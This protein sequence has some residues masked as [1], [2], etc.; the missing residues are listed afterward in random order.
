M[1]APN[2][3]RTLGWSQRCARRFAQWIL[4]WLA[5]LG[6]LTASGCSWFRRTTPIPPPP[7]VFE[8]PPTLDQLLT[9]VNA[10][11]DRVLDVQTD[12]GRLTAE[13][14]PGLRANLRL[15]RPKHLRLQASFMTNQVLDMGS[16]AE[17]FWLW[18][19]GDPV[20]FAR[21]DQFASTAA[22]QLLPVEPTWLVD[23]LGLIHFEPTGGHR[24]PFQRSDG[25]I[26]VHTPIA[27]AAGPRVRVVAIHPQ[28]GYITE[29]QMRD[30]AGGLLAIA[31]ADRHRYDEATQVTLPHRVRLEL[32]TSQLP[33]RAFTFETDAYVINQLQSPDANPNL[34]VMPPG[35]AHDLAH[36]PV[37][38]GP[39]QPLQTAPAP[40]GAPQYQQFDAASLQ[41]FRPEYRGYQR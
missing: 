39:A 14:Y 6:L 4:L 20:L 38:L 13:G 25:M 22:V 10:Q 17:R 16:N 3:I 9:A 30:Q 29:V 15:L 24:G 28:Y 34:W 27:S 1:T 2:T 41:G 11:S 21:H 33:I 26:E 23:A 12:S 7:Q 37:Q 36:G 32:M 18:S 19:M 8:Q 5:A 40:S 35:P 31:Q